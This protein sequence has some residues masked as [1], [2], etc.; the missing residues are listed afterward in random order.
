MIADND[1]AIFGPQNS[2]MVAVAIFD[3]QQKR[4]EKGKTSQQMNLQTADIVEAGTS[5]RLRPRFE[6]KDL[7]RKIGRN[8]I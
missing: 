2:L 1:R 3:E 8:K 4:K 7:G 6:R 5:I